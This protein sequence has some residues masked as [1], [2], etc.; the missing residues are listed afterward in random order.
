MKLYELLKDTG[1]V[2]ETV[3]IDREIHA[4]TCDSRRV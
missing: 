3:D 2:P 4:I 1:L